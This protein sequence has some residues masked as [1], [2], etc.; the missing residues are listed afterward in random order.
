MNIFLT[1]LNI[2][3]DLKNGMNFLNLEYFVV[4]SEEMNF[5]KA[6][7][8]LYISQQSLSAHIH[9]LEHEFGLPL[10]DRGIPLQ[11]TEAGTYFLQSAKVILDE[12][13]N[14]EKHL[15]DLRDF[16]CGDLTIGIPSSRSAVVLPQLVINFQKQFPQ[17]NIHLVEGDSNEITQ[18]L[19]DK[20]TDITIGFE[21]NDPERLA[22]ERL[23]LETTQIVVPN[24]ILE[25]YFKTRAPLLQGKALP[26]H[27]FGDCPFI[28][29][30]KD[31]WLGNVLYGACRKEG[32]HPNIVMETKNT[33]SMLSLCCGGAGICICPSSFLSARWSPLSRQLLSSATTFPLLYEE[34]QSW[35]TLS[36]LKDRYLS[37]AARAFTK[38]AK[39]FY[40][41]NETDSSAEA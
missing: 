33:I 32:F 15:S 1:P 11:L 9:K 35:I 30:N 24:Q 41:P 10:F 14:L 25:Q 28:G 39:Q 37:L 38:I 20:R 13:A 2:R 36:H 18:A 17:V 29:I 22:S 19:Y 26:L 23:Y 5:S 3:K 16:Q 12:K 31:T 6:A 7:A 21:L 8:R 4:L 40:A 34:G 27:I